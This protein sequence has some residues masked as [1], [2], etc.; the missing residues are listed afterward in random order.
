MSMLRYC[1]SPFSFR[2]RPS[3]EVIVGDPARVE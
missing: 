3:R 2:R 1:D